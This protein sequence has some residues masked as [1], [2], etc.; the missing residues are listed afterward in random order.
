M[1]AGFPADGIS[2]ETLPTE[3]LEGLREVA[4]EVLDEEAARDEHFAKILKSQREFTATY[5]H[6]S[7]KAYLPRDF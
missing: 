4:N 3:I 1:I 5:I 2:A 7:R 6:W